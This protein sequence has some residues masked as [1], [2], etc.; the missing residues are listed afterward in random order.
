MSFMLPPRVSCGTGAPA[1]ASLRLVEG[2]GDVVELVVDVV[3][4]ERQRNDDDDRDERQ[5]QRVLDQA[6]SALLVAEPRYH[7]LHASSSQIPL[8]VRHDYATPA[9]LLM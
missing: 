5:D 7:V 8:H 6:L 9:A 4:E 1:A 2:V 3:A